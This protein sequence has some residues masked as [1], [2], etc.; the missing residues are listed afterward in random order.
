MLYILTSRSDGF[1]PR[2]QREFLDGV[3]RAVRTEKVAD[4]ATWERA[5]AVDHVMRLLT[6][7]FFSQL[8]ALLTSNS[9]CTLHDESF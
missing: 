1:S 3:E 4:K 5:G 9:L 7:Y 8:Q 6:L 2:F